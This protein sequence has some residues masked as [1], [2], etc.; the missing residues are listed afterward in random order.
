[1]P[2]V[3]T[4]LS[5]HPP[6]I[7]PS[8]GSDKD[9]KQ[10]EK[11]IES[12][13]SLREKFVEA[14]PQQILIASP[15]PDWGFNVPLFFLAK[16]FKGKIKTYLIGTEEPEFYFN[17]GKRVYGELD[18]DKKYALIVSGDLSHCLKKDGPYGFHPD[19]PKFD[20]ELLESLKRKISKAF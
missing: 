19:G 14:E 1:M 13:H 9:R 17:E 5:P 11:T 7:L 6:I 16:E 3:F 10:V 8:V 18:K 4:A 12:L 15:H 20:E 2:I